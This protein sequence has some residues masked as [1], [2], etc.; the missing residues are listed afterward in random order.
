MCSK[1][2]CLP[3]LCGELVKTFRGGAKWGNLQHCWHVLERMWG[4]FC[5]F[6]F[7]FWPP[8]LEQTLYTTRCYCGIMPW[9][10]QKKKKKKSKGH[11]TINW[12]FWNCEPNYSFPIVSVLSQ[13][14]VS[15]MGTGLYICCFPLWC[16]WHSFSG[17]SLLCA[18]SS[19]VLWRFL[20]GSL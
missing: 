3:M 1:M 2:S 18:Q 15:V 7:A 6:V 17:M 4:P 20:S 12:Q 19:W 5:L 8:W 9:Q 11:S 14:L 16:C 13:C 10:Y